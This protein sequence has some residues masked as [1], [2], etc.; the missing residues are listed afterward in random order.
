VSSDGKRLEAMVAFVERQFLPQ[1]CVVKT[2]RREYNENG[3]QI[4]EFDIEVRGK[5]GTTDIAWLIECRDRP[6]EGPAPG[7]WIEQLFG[8]KDRF[9][10]N[11]VTAVSTTGFA[12]G[13]LGYARQKG[14]EAREVRSLA[15][16]H[17]ADWLGLR[18][19]HLSQQILHLDH[20]A[21]LVAE[22]E[23][24]ERRKAL[25]EV[26]TGKRSDDPVLRS[27]EDGKL[28]SPSQAFVVAVASKPSLW[29]DVMPNGPAKA[30]KLTVRYSNEDS[31]FVVET[32]VGPVR[33][34]EILFLGKLSIKQVQVPLAETNEYG[35]VESSEPI[36]Q[37]ASFLFSAVGKNLS[38]DMHKLME[39]GETHVGLRILRKTTETSRGS[40]RC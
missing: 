10:F 28:V 26:I 23:H 30:V 31:H 15:P 25:A 18:T 36:A 38:L 34:A 39:S 7:S 22:A 14:I 21:I 9:G 32:T 1:G 3:V 4:A 5:F 2:N 29:Y 12:A 6:S 8:R 37:S 40:E 13:A 20:A 24:S 19:F 35:I 27:T 17:F 33:I 11:K 16:E